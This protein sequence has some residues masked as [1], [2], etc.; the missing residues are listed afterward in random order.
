MRAVFQDLDQAPAVDAPPD[1]A[2]RPDSRAILQ[3]GVRPLGSDA[4]APREAVLAERLTIVLGIAQRLTR[5]LDRQEILRTIVDE[6]DRVLGADGSTIRILV[7]DRLV[8][9][10]WA[11]MTDDA[12]ARLPEVRRDESWF[13]EVLRRRTPLAIDDVSRTD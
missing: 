12:A 11:G 2:P 4:G 8:P 13:G 6:A 9:A 5:T 3:R 7:G 10:A 1:G